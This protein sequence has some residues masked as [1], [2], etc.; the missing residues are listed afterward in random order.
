MRPLLLRVKGLRSY[1]SER[2]IDFSE[3][4]LA[5]IVGDTGAGKSSILEA[6]C[7][8]LYGSSSW[9]QRGVKELISHGADL[10][11]VSL[12]FRA[13]G[14]EWEVYRSTPK[15]SYPPSRSSLVC[16]ALGVRL[17]SKAEVDARVEALVGLDYK[18]FLRCVILPQGRFQELLQARPAER[19]GL[20]KGVFGLDLLERVRAWADDSA[21]E[22]APQLATL[23]ER[24]AALLEDPEAEAEAAAAALAVARARREGLRAE[25]A[26]HREQAERAEREG[27]RAKAL[28]AARD[29][30]AA[31]D[32]DAI[33]ERLARVN[34]AALAL[35][36][37]RAEMDARR[38]AL[39]EHS[40]A[41]A[42]DE[43]PSLRDLERAAEILTEAVEES[44][45]LDEMRA[46]LAEAEAALEAASV[47]LER[48]EAAF[49]VVERAHERETLSRSLSGLAEHIREQ[50]MPGDDCP[51]CSRPIAAQL[52]LSISEGGEAF[53]QTEKAWSEGGERVRAA[54][55]AHRTLV[56]QVEMERSALRRDSA[57]LEKRLAKVLAALRPVAEAGALPAAQALRAAL[58]HAERERDARAIEEQQRAEAERERD[59][60]EARA[61]SLGARQAAEV[62][63]PARELR[64]ALDAGAAARRTLAAALAEDAEDSERSDEAESKPAS[65]AQASE[66]LVAD[67][68]ESD[69][70][71]ALARAFEEQRAAAPALLDAAA[72]RV[73]AAARA[74]DQ[75]AAAAAAVLA[76]AGFDDA[77][78]FERGLGQCDA[79]IGQH[80]RQRAQAESQIAPAR[81]L[82]QRIAT[83]SAHLDAL[84]EL[85]RQMGDGK[86]VGHVVA[87]K[88]EA[89]LT[90]A[91]R[92]LGDMSGRRFGFGGDFTVIDRRAG[93]ARAVETLSGGESFLASLALALALVELTGRGGGKLEALF[94]DEGFGSL[95]ADAL[96]LAIEALVGQAQRGRLVAVISHL[97]AVAERIDEVLYVEAEPEGSMPRWLDA[98]ERVALSEDQTEL[99]G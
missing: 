21:R 90:V 36:Q 38:G 8:A 55:D 11:E 72:A 76:E 57:R 25:Q 19:T 96:D 62:E 13:D 88:Q 6:I 50:L 81:A 91:S 44:V 94:L 41:T 52:E 12:R 86:F 65:E 92:L 17:D 24:R 66:A 99:L 53:E 4:T 7:Y 98:D 31:V 60:L 9:N 15:G 18:A 79:E 73:D 93:E 29:A 63:L 83:A 85:R 14:H 97:R 34:Q 26:R 3:R 33:A 68:G 75:A 5:A 35:S 16:E 82:D 71:A 22:R 27:A 80:E 78:A 56:Q 70:L 39:A 89:L 48:E 59:A 10:M 30:L 95:D 43:G 67:T 46:A 64:R 23:R 45:Q 37:E 20:L 58:A 87:R 2:T 77:A 84:E 32:G 42:D 61:A 74:R 49:L 1:A 28:R 69:E 40:A 47:T 51:V 54:R